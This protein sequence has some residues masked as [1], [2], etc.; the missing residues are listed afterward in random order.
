MNRIRKED[1]CSQE[2]LETPLVF[3]SA[4]SF[5]HC[6]KDQNRWSTGNGRNTR[7]LELLEKYYKMNETERIE[8]D[9]SPFGFLISCSFNGKNCSQNHLSHFADFRYGSCITYNKIQNGRI[10]EASKF[11]VGSGLAL[12]LNLDSACYLLTGET[13]GAKIMIH[14]PNE[15]PNPED[16]GF[17]LSPGFEVLIALKQTVMHR[18]EYPY[19]DRCIHY[20]RNEKDFTRSKRFCIRSCIQRHNFARCNCIDPTSSIKSTF[21][22]CSL[23]NYTEVC[24]LSDVLNDLSLTKL[25]CDCPLPCISVYNKRKISKSLL[26]SE[27]FSRNPLVKNVSKS[28]ILLLNV[29]YSSFESYTYHQHPKY[30]T[31]KLMSYI[32]SECALWLGLSFVAFCDIIEKLAICVKYMYIKLFNQHLSAIHDS[33]E[34]R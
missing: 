9:R 7:A 20:K 14:D 21:K 32:G 18:L 16:E 6:M 19:K 2:G 25:T 13:V 15:D 26:S 31:T 10:I 8:N 30:E 4:A 27:A 28:K 24:C 34:R 29:F 17:T 23:T 5:K 3:S 22:S 33:D 1:L 11:G 12:T